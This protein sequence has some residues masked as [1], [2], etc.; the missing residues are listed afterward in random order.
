MCER[1]PSSLNDAEASAVL[2]E[3][4]ETLEPLL[5]SYT[6]YS[7]DIV[8]L[9]YFPYIMIVIMIFRDEAEMMKLYHIKESD[10][11]YY[12]LFALVVIPFQITAD[13]F[14]HN[15]L[16]LLH[17][18]KTYEYIEYC[19]VRFL[20]REMW[21]KGLETNTLDECINESLRSIDQ[22]CFSSQYYMLNT[23]HVNAIIYLVLGIVMMA[24][25]KYNAFGDPAM[26]SIVTIVLLCSIVVKIVLTHVA[27]FFGLWSIRYEKRRWHQRIQSDGE[28]KIEQWSNGQTTAHSEYKLEEKMISD[29]FRYK[30]LRY[31]RSWIIDQLPSMLNDREA[32]KSRPYVI[33]QLARILGSIDADI[34]SDDSEGDDAPEFETPLMNA[35]TRAMLRTWF[36]EAS[37]LLRLSRLVE[38][39]IQKS[40][41]DV[42]QF[43]L[44]RGLLRVETCYPV[45]EMNRLFIEEYPDCKDEIDQVLW[46]RF[47]Q[48]NQK[49]QTICF[50]CLQRRSHEKRESIIVDDRSSDDADSS[51]G[52]LTTNELDV[53]SAAILSTWYSKAKISLNRE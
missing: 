21:W 7:C 36:G 32:S 27:K 51:I 19:R 8:T 45:E 35:S 49:Y 24:R 40:R 1:N 11:E 20:Q 2:E 42:C 29:T 25:A 9:M 3:N 28:P 12:V 47:W 46:K 22:M 4:G 50:P 13:I 39:I 16:E 30:F 53:V 34:S 43:C 31:N 37:R 38:P 44:S 52:D 10:M 26:S 23:L 41:G 18:W 6:S 15:A 33:N 5:G 17:G 48:R 14:L